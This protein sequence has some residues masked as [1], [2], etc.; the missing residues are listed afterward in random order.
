MAV[1]ASCARVTWTRPIRESDIV[2]YMGGERQVMDAAQRSQTVRPR[3]RGAVGTYYPHSSP[4][5]HHPW[6][7]AKCLQ[8]VV[9][10]DSG[11]N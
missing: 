2:R 10:H 9:L 11:R 8:S 1:L 5:G 4:S 6:F 7:L 3:L